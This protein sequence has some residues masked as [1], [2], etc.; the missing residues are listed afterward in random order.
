MSVPA[1]ETLGEWLPVWLQLEVSSRSR[2]WAGKERL[3]RRYVT[4]RYGRLRL[5]DLTPE[6][7]QDALDRIDN[8]ATRSEV[9]ELLS[10]SLDD[11]KRA[12][13]VS[14]NPARRVRTVD[15][16]MALL[17]EDDDAV[18]GEADEGPRTVLV[19]DH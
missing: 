14:T 4:I 12:G 3:V 11:A 7:L 19:N 15:T 10:D 5:S 6:M 16:T 2:Y 1:A 9:L 18:L 13:L 17:D 8:Y